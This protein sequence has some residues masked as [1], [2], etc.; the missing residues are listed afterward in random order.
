MTGEVHT[1]MERATK[2][3]Q[4]RMDRDS[5][6]VILFPALR[7]E[8][9]R[10]TLSGCFPVCPLTRHE[11]HAPAYVHHLLK[12]CIS[13][14]FRSQLASFALAVSDWGLP[15]KSL[16]PC[17]V[18]L[19]PIVPCSLALMFFG[20]RLVAPGPPS[21]LPRHKSVAPSQTSVIRCTSLGH[22]FRGCAFPRA[23]STQVAPALRAWSVPAFRSFYVRCFF[24][25]FALRFCLSACCVR[26]RDPTLS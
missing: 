23:S 16:L 22:I 11:M 4:L 2:K 9:R 25:T 21:C 12:I 17:P 24:R 13:C 14:S 5:L 26:Q 6:K 15:S 20:N 7:F 8:A 10:N 1:G 19:P 18:L 3:L